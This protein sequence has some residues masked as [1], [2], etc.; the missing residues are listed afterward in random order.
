MNAFTEEEI[1]AAALQKSPAERGA[2]LDRACQGDTLLRS[3]VE[4]LLAAFD[5]PDSFLDAP[6]GEATVDRPTLEAPGAMI[7]PYKLLQ[8]IGEGGF[9]IVFMAEQAE[10]V[11]RRVALKVI[12]PGMDTRQVIA[13]FEAE[14][15]ALALMDHP[16]IAKVLDGGT[17]ATGRPY[18][19]MELVRGTP[20]TQYCDENLQS[21]RQRLELFAVV[22]QAIQHA[23]TKGII[24][25]D[26][27]PTNVLV[28]SQ[29]GQPLVKVIDFGVA[30]AL[31]QQLTDKTLFTEFAQMIGTPLY[32]S[33]EQAEL[34]SVDIDMRSDVF[35]LGVLLYELLTGSTPVTKEQLKQAAFDEIRRLIREEDPPKPSTRISTAESAPSIA[36]Q[37]HT[38]PAK[39]A[40]L[41]RGELDW[42]V[43][44][45]LEKD[46]NRR[47]ETASG[48]AADVQRYLADE[49]VL[50]CPPSSVYR[51][52]K[53]LRRHKVAAI[54]TLVVAASLL[55]A[56]GVSIWQAAV[57]R[58][59]EASA[60]QRLVRETQAHQ[61]AAAINQLLLEGLSSANPDSAKGT[62]YTVRQLLDEIS[63][64][65]EDQLGDQ[66]AAEA[67]IRATIGSAYFRLGLPEKA[68]PHLKRSLELRE[69]LYGPDS[70]EV[71][72]GLYDEAWNLQEYGDVPGALARANRALAIHRKAEL[73]NADTVRLLWLF[74]L[75]HRRSGREDLS[76]EVGQ[77]ALA[78]ARQLPDASGELAD[79]LHTLAA[80][81]YRLRRDFA[82]A[83]KMTRESIAL[84][85]KYR[86]D[87]HP[88]TGRA[89]S[90]L[91]SLL[92]DQGKLD[93]AEP[94]LRESLAIFER[95]FD[96][97]S[98]AHVPSYAFLVMA[99][100]GKKDQAGLESLR[101]DVTKRAKRLREER[102]DDAGPLFYAAL[103]Q[104]LVGDADGAVETL[105]QIAV[106]RP[107]KH[108][109]WY[110]RIDQLA[111]TLAV[112]PDSHERYPGVALDLAQQAIEMAPQA[113]EVWSTLGIAQYR[114]ASWQAAV[115]ALKKSVELKSRR[116]V[117][118][119]L[120]LAMAHWQL[121]EKETARAWYD[122]ATHWMDQHQ[123]NRE[124][125]KLFRAEAEEVMRQEPESEA[126]GQ[127]SRHTGRALRRA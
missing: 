114:A 56:T 31:G 21:I 59:A 24:H 61:Q 109:V 121:G 67:A 55:I 46:R 20:I 127:E 85:R 122:K 123:P 72:R 63:A 8:Q 92:A 3:S 86:G 35:S 19:V 115:A 4:A 27:K 66:P 11:R 7:G 17:T 96:Y 88:Q 23:H 54:A 69:K 47:Y 13:R 51:L 22:C 2:F 40:K 39:L 48:F 117:A 107:G 106:R 45:A 65:L 49:P 119:W 108:K 34:S 41:V 43:M 81:V 113:G 74:Q 18:F 80:S 25:R 53:F 103:A 87:H 68:S 6:L 29:D 83:E 110:F 5:R 102:P 84:H 36:A 118:C 71:A 16:N 70:P 112:R 37:R 94:L 101:E 126:G 75:L 58:R 1:F 95:N 100:R 98:E 44:K 97:I 89:L 62:D 125:L 82:L 99:L 78:L 73:R 30:K 90:Q 50:A 28:T 64:R 14:R 15:Q 76:E 57:A 32:M 91:G 104:A 38:E 9:G 116:D 52:Q 79:V 77:E 12:K 33:P 10:P 42:I 93:E 124:E 111:F 60:A 105:S 120:F 26:I